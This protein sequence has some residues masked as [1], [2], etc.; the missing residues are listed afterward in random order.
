MKI[1]RLVHTHYG[2]QKC[3]I[4]LMV[5]DFIL[6]EPYGIYD[7]G[8]CRIAE[9]KAQ[10]MPPGGASGLAFSLVTQPTQDLLMCERS[11]M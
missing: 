4:Y 9:A 8:C 7:N 3:L 5:R 11:I 1:L 6:N 2:V 10:D